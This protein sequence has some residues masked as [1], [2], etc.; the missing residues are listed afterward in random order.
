MWCKAMLVPELA[1]GFTEIFMAFQLRLQ[2]GPVSLPLSYSHQSEEPTLVR[3]LHSL[4]LS[5]YFPRNPTCNIANVYQQSCD[6]RYAT[7]S[8]LFLLKN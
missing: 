1:V 2:F 7:T 3:I 4:P 5:V 8:F 6:I